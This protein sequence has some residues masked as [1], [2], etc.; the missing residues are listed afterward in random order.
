VPHRGGVSLAHRFAAAVAAERNA[1]E[2]EGDGHLLPE[3]L[4]RATAR[5]L[6]V[7]GAGLSVLAGPHGR[8]PL[9]AS[10]PD[11]ARAE[12]LQFTVGSGPCLLAHTSGQPVFVVEDDIRVRWPAFA[13]LLFTATPYRGIVCLPLRP[14]ISGALDLFLENADDV[15]RVD[16]FD[17]IAVGDLLTSALA[18]AAVWSTW[19]EAEGPAW[20]HS[21]AAQRRAVVWTAVGRTGAALGIDAPEALAL[22]RGRAYSAGR[23][24]DSVAA[25]LVSGRLRPDDVAG[26]P[27]AD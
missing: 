26:R 4:A 14:P 1:D 21:P 27:G 2:G 12:R 23:S 15:A 16:V 6:A 25:D 24:V 11:A 10:S 20:L 8:S 13:D 7:D 22:L 3:Q 17:A 5:A 19:S 18:D 9:G